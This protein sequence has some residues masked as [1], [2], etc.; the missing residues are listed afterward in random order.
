MEFGA[1]ALGNR[2]ILA[3]PGAPAVVDEINR[4]IKRRDFWMPFAPALLAEKAECYIRSPH[5]LP[6]P[7]LSPYMMHAFD[8]TELR[9]HMVASIHIADGTARAQLVWSDLN[10]EFHKIIEQ[11]GRLTCRWAVLNTSFNL[12]GSPIVAG[13]CNALEVFLQSKLEYLFIDQCLVT[14][15]SSASGSG[16]AAD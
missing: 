10:P 11:F 13:A 8:T 7:R 6:R 14:K 15:R 5:S 3:D 2:S 12:H 16:V 9:N 1:R 4:R